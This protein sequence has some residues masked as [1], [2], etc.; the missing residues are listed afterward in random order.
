MRLSEIR[1]FPVKSMLGE[2]PTT[3]RLEANG[4]VG[5]RL[6]AVRDVET[7]KVA[8]AKRPR[9]WGHLLRMAACYVGAP[10]PGQP[11]AVTL[12]SGSVL[13][14]RESDFNE[15][16]SAAIGRPV[17]LVAAPEPAARYD[18]EW[19][20]VPGVMPEE[21]AASRRTSTTP[22]GRG[23]STVSMGI[24]APG[25]FHDVA[26]VT[27]IT[28]AT[29]R[30]AAQLQPDS[31]WDPRRFRANLLIDVDRSAFVENDWVGQQ[32]RVGE[33][34]LEI[35]MPTPRCVMTTL[36]QENLGRDPE[37]LRAVARHNRIDVGGAGLYA[38]LGAYA[39][40]VEPGSASAGDE[41]ELR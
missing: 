37:I 3:A 40:V 18:Y 19:P 16:L 14:S 32:L 33:V 11:I 7:G 34:L 38:C 29:L 6:Y 2:M 12:P 36:P 35:R 20:D 1:R 39:I 24:I 23:V 25:T 30:K 17:E 8:S 9:L 22:E 21:A 10:G 27:I 4:F 13:H 15:R 28:T 5:D 41:V 26:P 31:N